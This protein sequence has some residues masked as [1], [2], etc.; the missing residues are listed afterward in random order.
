MEM[1]YKDSPRKIIIEEFIDTKIEYKLWIFHGKCQFIKI[2]IMNDFAE[3]GK[4]A[5]QYGKYFYPDWVPADFRTIGKEPEYDIPKPKKLSEMIKI[6][7]KW[8]KPFDFVRV[9]FYET[10][11]DEL[12]FGEITFSPAAGDIHFVPESKNVEFG[13]LFKIPPRDENGFAKNK[14][15]KTQKK[16]S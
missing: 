2:E 5:N 12:K 15:T 7:E 14:M 6:A 13:R 9:D 11:N 1:Q 8:A 16:T 4:P 3:N 10:K